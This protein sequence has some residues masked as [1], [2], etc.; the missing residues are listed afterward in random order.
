MFRSLFQKS[1]QSIGIDLEGINVV[2]LHKKRSE[3][4]VIYTAS[5][6][7]NSG[8]EKIKFLCDFFA[9]HK[10]RSKN[11]YVA[12]PVKHTIKKELQF[13]AVLQEVDI[14]LQLKLE[15]QRYFPGITEKLAYDFAIKNITEE[16]QN[17][18]VY[19]TKQKLLADRLGLLCDAKIYPVC[20]EPDG[21]AWLRLID[22]IQRERLT[23][24]KVGVLLVVQ[25]KIFKII[26]FNHHEILYEHDEFEFDDV[27]GLVRRNLNHFTTSNFKYK[28]NAFY[29]IG[30]EDL[31]ASLRQEMDLNIVSVVAVESKL[32]LAY[33]LALRGFDDHH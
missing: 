10:I 16:K 27:V 28:L 15:Q 19:A 2:V 18:I 22:P 11:I 32:L 14:K 9:Q 30:E 4:K 13:A 21:F 1:Q 26:I 33:G 12:I 25:H 20:V 8:G 5:G 3:I 7:C 23:E 31:I 24:D 17:V 6:E 29:F